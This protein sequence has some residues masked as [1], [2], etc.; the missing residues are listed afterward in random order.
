MSI[1]SAWTLQ[2]AQ[3]NLRNLKAA[4]QSIISGTA[5]SYKV[6]SREYTAL[7]TKELIDAINY[8]GNVVRSL[9][10]E[11]RTTRVCRVVPRDL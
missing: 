4:Y 8:F 5:K 2:E 7:D 9:S 3:D 10:G 6:G 1:K 11:A